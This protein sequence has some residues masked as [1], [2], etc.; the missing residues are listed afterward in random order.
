MYSLC[1]KNGD[2]V[3]GRERERE[4]FDR[5]H[6]CLQPGVYI[7]IFCIKDDEIETGRERGREREREREQ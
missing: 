4:N 2:I 1:I 5:G 7:T 3:A 6:L